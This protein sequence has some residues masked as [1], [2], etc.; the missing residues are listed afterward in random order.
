MMTPKI[1]NALSAM[2][3]LAAPPSLLSV[4]NHTGMEVRSE[5][6]VEKIEKK[7]IFVK[8]YSDLKEKSS[9]LISRNT[10]PRFYN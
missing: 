5:H 2:A 4:L 1:V 10:T 7:I 3:I 8:I 9:A 6:V